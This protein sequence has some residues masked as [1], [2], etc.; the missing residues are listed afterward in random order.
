MHRQ[1]AVIAVA[2]LLAVGLASAGL[3]FSGEEPPQWMVIFTQVAAS[4]PGW[5]NNQAEAWTY[6]SRSRIVA[7]DLREPD[8]IL[9]MLTED[10]YSARASQISYDGKRV[11]FAGQKHEGDSWQIWEMQ[12]NGSQA[13]QVTSGAGEYTDPAY[14]PGSRIVYSGRSVDRDTA[15]ALYTSGL[16]GSEVTRITFHPNSDFG[17]NV[18]RNGRIVFASR[19][20]DHTASPSKLMIVR[21]DGTG[22]HLFY[23]S[24][25]GARHISRAWE[26]RD[27]RVVFVESSDRDS[28]GG[29]LI[30]VSQNRP[31]RSRV[32]LTAGIEG[33]F[34]SV[35]PL[36]SGKLIVSYLP[37]GGG[38]FGLY[39]FDP[40][41]SRLGPVVS[42]QPDYHAVEPLLHV[43]RS[44]PQGLVSVVDAQQK[45]G[46]F[47]GLN[48][49]LSDLAV[50]GTA[51]SSARSAKVRVI[52]IGG[53]LGEVPLEEDGSFYFEIPADTPVR[54]QTVDEEG[55]VVRGPSAWIW[56]RPNERR[57]CIGCHEDR[58]LAP[59]NRVPMAI[60][61]PPVSLP[62]PSSPL[63]AD[64]AR[65]SEGNDQ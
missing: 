8:R 21:S 43:T 52:G 60:E 7:L 63:S 38:S 2:S 49:D 3:L 14:L 10:F 23:E 65:R 48:A 15:Y 4:E 56:V 59:A 18:L 53:V 39:E 19:A 24:R 6:P 31:L 29:K 13:R 25:P 34:H 20:S 27:G 61:K 45:T 33:T 41:E 42:S 9:K 11:L 55:R 12:R 32:V 44:Q 37:P 26:T 58:E 40:L 51:H 28:V 54:L 64:A 1:R 50:T 22:A 62:S 30:A 57:G 5:E 16:D 17:S 36:P 47:Y 35:F 46:W